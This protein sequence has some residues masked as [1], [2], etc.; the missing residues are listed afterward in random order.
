MNKR[1]L[2]AEQKKKNKHFKWEELLADEETNNQLG[3]FLN[4]IKSRKNLKAKSE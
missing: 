4:S 2:K 3:G 1:N